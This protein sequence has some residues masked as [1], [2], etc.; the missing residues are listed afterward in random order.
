LWTTTR[1]SFAWL[2]AEP[3]WAGRDDHAA[4]GDLEGLDFRSPSQLLVVMDDSAKL[5]EIAVRRTSTDRS[6]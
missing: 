6:R 3:L 1:A 2:V 4:L 5:L